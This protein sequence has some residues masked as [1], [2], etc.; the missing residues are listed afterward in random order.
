MKTVNY[1]F[2]ELQLHYDLSRLASPE[3]T[4]FLDIE[5]TGFSSKTSTLYLIGGC[6]L[7]DGCW[8]GIQWFAE[9]PAEE[10]QVIRAFLDFINDYSTLIHFNGN[11][12][13]LPFISSRAEKLGL[14]CDF[15]NYEGIDIYKRTFPCRHFL[16]LNNCKQKTIEKFLGIDREDAYSGGELIQVYE[17]YVNTPDPEKEQLLLLHNRDDLQGML[18]I[19]PILAYGDLFNQPLQVT[20]VQSNHYRDADNRMQQ[21]L[22]IRLS[23]FSPVPVPIS[24]HAS[25]CYVMAEDSHAVL[26]VPVYTEELKYYYTDYKNYYYLPL[27]DTAI[28][29][30]VASFVDKSHRTQATAA[31]C[32]SRK[33]SSYLPQWDYLFTPFFKRDY[34][35]S[36][37][38]FE[39]TEELK[40]DRAAFARYA[41]HVLAML[42]KAD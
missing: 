14:A 1:N 4:F 17:D 26:R 42:G 15:T 30:S 37:L 9:T 5:T 3:K 2:N 25:D 11:Q 32:Y 39:L 21:E 36:L 28:H 34:K 29:K 12:F 18:A 16:G 13:D 31:T 6:Y 23:L 27:E 38:F 41:S 24:F 8:Q 19:L 10:A 7:Q 22:I 35:S 20:K 40:T 33:Y